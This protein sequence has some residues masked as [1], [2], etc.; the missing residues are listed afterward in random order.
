IMDKLHAKNMQTLLI[1]HLA[2]LN[3][4]KNYKKEYDAL[5]QQIAIENNT[6][7]YPFFF[8]ALVTV[9]EMVPNIQLYFQADGLHPNA[10]GVEALVSD[11]GPYVLR[12][13][14]K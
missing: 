14:E 1:G 2:P 8:N 6:E 11:I 9:G 5:F 10:A 3:Y 12:A 13:L 4:G 7:F